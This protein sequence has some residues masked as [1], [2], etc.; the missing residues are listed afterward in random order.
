MPFPFPLKWLTLGGAWAQR[1]PPEIP[2][3]IAASRRESLWDCKLV[4]RASDYSGHLTIVCIRNNC[5]T[6]HRLHDVG[7]LGKLLH[8][9][10]YRAS[11]E[12]SAP[13]FVHLTRQVQLSSLPNTDAGPPWFQL[14]KRSG[15]FFCEEVCSCGRMPFRGFFASGNDPFHFPF[16]FPFDFPL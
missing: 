15:R 14:I 4:S 7:D 2:V 11:R 13:A 12:N 5:F 9:T 1:P 6:I 3:P 16:S 8:Q 10:S